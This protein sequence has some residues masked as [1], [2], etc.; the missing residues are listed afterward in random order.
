MAARLRF[1]AQRYE[2][3]G[4]LN[5]SIANLYELLVRK[6]NISAERHH[7]RSQRFFFGMLGAQLGVIISTFAM[8]ARK[9]NLLWSLAAGAGVLAVGF[10]IYVY[11]CI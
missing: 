5:Q 8:A 7:V 3:E 1:A 9:R 10:A 6:S 4:R 11:L 2:V